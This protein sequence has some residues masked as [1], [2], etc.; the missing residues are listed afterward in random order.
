MPRLD[1]RNQRLGTQP[2]AA[3]RQA[4]SRHEPAAAPPAVLVDQAANDMPALDPGGDID[5]LAGLPLR[6]FLLQGLVRTML[7]I[8]LGVPGQDLA[9]MPFAENQHAVQALAPQRARE[10]L[11]VGIRP[12]RSPRSISKLRACWA[13]QAAVECA[14]MPR[15]CTVRV[16]ISITNST[17]MR[18]SSTVSTCRKSQARMPDAWA[19]RNCRQ[20]GAG[21]PA[22]IAPPAPAPRPAQAAGLGRWGRSISS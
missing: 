17:Y 10:P 5:G 11:R 2:R 12:A 6:G 3:R 18:W 14:V 15:M 16:W 20:V 8:V 4:I 21:S 9:E 7:V 19:A 1:G 13:V 22:P